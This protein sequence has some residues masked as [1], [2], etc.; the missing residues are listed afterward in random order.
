LLSSVPFSTKLLF[1]TV[2]WVACSVTHSLKNT[3]HPLELTITYCST[4]NVLSITWK[5]KAVSIAKQTC[6]GQFLFRV[7]LP[8][9]WTIG[10]KFWKKIKTK[11]RKQQP[12]RTNLEPTQKLILSRF[13]FWFFFSNCFGIRHVISMRKKIKVLNNNS[14]ILLNNNLEVYV[15]DLSKVVPWWLS[16]GS[17]KLIHNGFPMD[18]ALVGAASH[19]AWFTNLVFPFL[20]CTLGPVDFLILSSSASVSTQSVD[21]VKIY[22]SLYMGMCPHSFW[23]MFITR[24]GQKVVC[25]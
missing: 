24:T 18:G 21:G 16:C 15:I 10:S 13:Q 19:N 25:W 17:S 5:Y 12:A 2:P 6:V 20:P 22:L 11:T 3:S 4:T 9:T 7:W 23:G 1:S 14:N 8:S